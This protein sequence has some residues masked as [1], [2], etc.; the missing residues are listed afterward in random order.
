APPGTYNIAADG[1][2][3]LTQAIRRAGHI[4]LPVMPQTFKLAARLL[5]SQGLRDI[6]PSQLRYLRYGRTMDT[7]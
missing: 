4:P 2:L 6:G 3:T 7:T 5:S 1:I